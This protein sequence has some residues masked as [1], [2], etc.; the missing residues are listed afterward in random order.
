MSSDTTRQTFASNANSSHMDVMTSAQSG[1]DSPIHWSEDEEAGS[2]NFAGG[3]LDE[4]STAKADANAVVGMSTDL[5]K[6]VQGDKA[7]T[8]E[9]EDQ[10]MQDLS[11]KMKRLSTSQAGSQASGSQS[12]PQPSSQDTSSGH[13]RQAAADKLYF[14]RAMERIAQSKARIIPRSSNRYSVLAEPVQPSPARTVKQDQ[15]DADMLLAE[16]LVADRPKRLRSSSAEPSPRPT[17]RARTE[18]EDVEMGETAQKP[19]NF[20]EIV[21]PKSSS[22]CF[23][24]ADDGDWFG[25]THGKLPNYQVNVRILGGR[26]GLPTVR[27]CFSI[28]KKEYFDTRIDKTTSPDAFHELFC[29]WQPGL[30]LDPGNPEYMIKDFEISHRLDVNKKVA[31]PESLATT[32]IDLLT[33]V[34]GVSFKSHRVI[35]EGPDSTEVDYIDP[36]LLNIMEKIQLQPCKVTLVCCTRWDRVSC[37][38]HSKAFSACSR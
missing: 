29:S 18:F 8:P 35:L 17:K 21:D 3:L 27:L 1:L 5:S 32:K 15:E 14:S 31:M 20:R 7:L 11:E 19:F 34:V 33:K 2:N 13:D 28:C 4:A 22:Q 36:A 26:L 6:Q 24:Q 9:P 30:I 37:E 25:A 10:T 38:E 12:E 23:I 16:E